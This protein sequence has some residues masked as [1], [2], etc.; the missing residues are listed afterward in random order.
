MKIRNILL[1]GVIVAAGATFTACSNPFGGGVADE[2]TEEETTAAETEPEPTTS[3]YSG[4]DTAGKYD[5]PYESQRDTHWSMSVDKL[6]VKKS[7]PVYDPETGEKGKSIRPTTHENRFIVLDISLEN[8]GSSKQTYLAYE[9][10][11]ITTELVT[12][13]GQKYVATYATDQEQ[14]FIDMPVSN[15]V[16]VKAGNSTKIYT[17][18]EVPKKLAESD[19]PLT[20]HMYFKDGDDSDG[21]YIKLR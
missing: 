16:D 2:T 3:V 6:E 5:S 9:N 18:I 13:D 8:T 10:A 11:D 12:G 1:T 17:A 7:L 14:G 15:W 20:Y 19:T 4:N 21:L